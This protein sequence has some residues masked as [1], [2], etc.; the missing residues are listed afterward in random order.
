MKDIPELYHLHY[1]Q[2]I[3][4]DILNLEMSK[5]HLV[6]NK[7]HVFALQLSGRNVIREI[8]YFLEII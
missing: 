1:L 2:N 6:V 3:E 4:F 5:N 8:E 7:L